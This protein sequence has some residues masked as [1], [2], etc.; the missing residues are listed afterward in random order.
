MYKIGIT[1]GDINGI[2]LETIIKALSNSKMTSQCTPIIYGSSKIVSY[3]KN[4]VK[5]VD[6]SFS[7]CTTP[8]KAS[9]GRVNVL[10]CWNEVVNV[11]LGNATSEGGKFAHIALDRAVS[12]LKKGDIDGIVTAPINKHTMDEVAFPYAGHTEYLNKSFGDKESLM[13]MV[14]DDLKVGLV[15]NHLPISKVA[16]AVTKDLVMKKAQIFANSLTKDF[17]IEKPTIAIL[18][19]NPHAGDEG[20]IGNEDKDI[21]RPAIIELKKKGLVAMGPYPADGFFGAGHFKKVD[22][23]L[24]IYHD[25]GLVPF[26][27]LTFGRGVNYTAGL[28]IVR[29]SPDHGT[30]YDIAGMN[31]ADPSSMRNAIFLAL[32]IIRSR[33]AYKDMHANSLNKKP[34]QTETVK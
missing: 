31:Q 21:I 33:K 34:K 11:E 20:K 8:H 9:P 16:S 28:S 4:I 27:A 10:N 7:T 6:F 25:Q 23:I 22:G 13:M 24:A 5:G 15:T 1:V 2:G 26:K 19:L 29:T 12:D 18:G 14:S 3:H 30:A 32:D 17:G